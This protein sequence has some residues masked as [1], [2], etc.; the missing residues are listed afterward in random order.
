MM[1]RTRH[2]SN[3][4]YM[5]W[6]GE[7]A[8]NAEVY[9]RRCRY[10]RNKY[11][12][13]S[14]YSSIGENMFATKASSSVFKPPMAIRKWFSENSN[15]NYYSRTCLSKKVCGHYTQV[16]WAESFKVGCAL[17][18]CTFIS[19]LQ[20]R[21]SLLFICYYATAGNVTG[22]DG[23]LVSVYEVGNACSKC[24]KDDYCRKSM[25]ANSERDFIEMPVEYAES[26]VIGF[27]I[28]IAILSSIVITLTLYIICQRLRKRR[29]IGSDCCKIKSPTRL[30]KSSRTKNGVASPENHLSADDKP[31]YD[32]VENFIP[33]LPKQQSESVLTANAEVTAKVQVRLTERP[34]SLTV[35]VRRTSYPKPSHTA[36]RSPP[37]SIPAPVLER[38]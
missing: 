12:K 29:L 22:E 7:L 9:G 30:R 13:H 4:R 23:K 16:V 2:S 21:N 25:C 28:A 15:F 10:R 5:T 11:K 36:P 35:P 37:P 32:S 14:K 6:D 27:I 1:R 17:T 20:Y 26:R 8:W 31:I 38:K 33:L 34:K 19:E 24:D 18:K 3:M